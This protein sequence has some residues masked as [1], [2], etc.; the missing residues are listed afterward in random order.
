MSTQAASVPTRVLVVDDNPDSVVIMRGML[1]PR[2]YKVIVANTGGIDEGAYRQLRVDQG[3]R[4]S[5]PVVEGYATAYELGKQ[6]EHVLG[7][8]L[9]S[10][11]PFRTYLTTNSQVPLEAFAAFLSQPGAVLLSAD[12][13]ERFGLTTG[14]RIRLGIGTVERTVTIVGLMRPPND[15]SSRALEGLMLADIATAQELFDM[16]GKLSRIDLIATPEQAKAIAAALPA[17]HLA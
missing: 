12:T 17:H 16:R 3:F 13:A 6:T 4:L 9:F 7:I 1:E 8:D 10:E 14:E 15:V 11:A 2:G 5:A